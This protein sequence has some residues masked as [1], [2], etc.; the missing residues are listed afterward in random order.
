[1]A[2]LRRI[3][4]L[5]VSLGVSAVGAGL[6]SSLP[7]ALLRDFGAEVARVESATP[8]TLDAGVEFARSWDRG[9]EI[10]RVDDDGVVGAVEGLARDADVLFMVGPER[11][12]ERRGLFP[13]DL[14]RS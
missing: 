9:K 2:P 14:A 3:R 12:L 11:A 13:G 8:S 7:G 1:M 10:V 6:A 5:E 4:V